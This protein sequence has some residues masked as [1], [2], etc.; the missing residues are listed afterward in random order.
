MVNNGEKVGIL[1]TAAPASIKRPQRSKWRLLGFITLLVVGVAFRYTTKFGPFS[2]IPGQLGLHDPKLCPQSDALYP[3]RHAKLWESLGDDFNRDAFTKRAV[4]WLGG[5]VRVPT[6]SYDKMGPVGVD[7]RWEVFGPFHDYVLQSFPLTHATLS[8]TKVNTYGLLYEWKG[9]DNSLKPLLL[10]AHQD[11]VPVEPKTVD[12]WKYPPFSGHYDGEFIWGRG[13]SDDKSGLIGALSSI[14]T[15]LEKNFKPTRTIILS[16]GFD[17][18]ASGVQGAQSLSRAILDKYGENSIALLVDEGG[19]FSEVGGSIIA[20]PG[21]AEKGYTDTRVTV[22]TAGGHSS[23]PPPHTSIG[24]LSRLLVEFEANP[25]RPRLERDTPIYSTVQCVG[26]HAKQFPGRLRALIKAS[27]HSDTALAKLEAELIKDET[28]KALIGTTQAIDLVQ[29]GVKTNALPEEA[30]AVINHRIATQ[31]SVASVQQRD[32]EVLKKLSKEFNLTFT[33]FGSTI[34]PQG[35]SN[36]GALTLSEAWGTALEPAPVTPTGENSAPWQLLS[37]TIKATYN[38]HRGLEGAD[39]VFVSPGIMSGNTDTRYYW[40]LTPHII[41]YNH[42]NMGKSGSALSNG[43]HTVNERIRAQ[44]FVEV[45]KF[46]T[47]LILNVDETTTF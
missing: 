7:K 31:S 40:K 37:G 5:A 35:G 47:M 42:W 41:R 39:N 8:L 20:V 26:Q 2:Y 23:V 16:F 38:V 1:P 28:Y 44:N 9:S 19:G 14:E 32:T 4:E 36:A 25:I 33:A 12:Q 29:G 10:A 17:E 13:S 46:F 24:I 43:I 15:L 45:I 11:V 27:V 34:S 6:E 21:I 3:D 18:E 30:W 22:S